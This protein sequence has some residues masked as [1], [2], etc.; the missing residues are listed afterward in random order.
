LFKEWANP[1]PLTTLCLIFGLDKSEKSIN[2]LHS[3]AITINKALFVLG[4]T[5]PRRRDTPNFKEKISIAFALIK[6]LGKIRELYRLVGKTNFHQVKDMFVQQGTSFDTPRP[7]FKQLPNAIYPLLDLML[8]F[9]TNLKSNQPKNK[10]L[11]FLQKSI[12]CNQI[13]FAEAIMAC[14]FIMFAGY[15]TTSSLLSNCVNHLAFNP[16]EHQ[17]LKD[18]PDEIDQFIDEAIRIYTP[19]GRF[20]RRAKRDVQISNTII[21]KGSIVILMLGAAN[22]DPKIFQN[23]YHFNSKRKNLNRSLSFGKGVHFCPGMSLAK[24]QTK[25]ALLNLIKAT[26][27][28]SVKENFN[29]VMVSDRDNGILRYEKLYF[30]FS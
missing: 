14:A 23:P 11:S 28:I 26:N 2:L 15:E 30:N 5:G 25:S 19:V 4:G 9:A 12:E 20:L 18:N 10:T 8:M 16:K 3:H 17:H 22:T 24:H 1:I 6:N 13:S 27:S 21:P 29:P 7:D